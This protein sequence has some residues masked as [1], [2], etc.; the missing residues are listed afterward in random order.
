MERLGDHIEIK[1]GYAFKS[2]HYDN[3]GI[4]IIRIANVQ[5]GFISDADPKFYSLKSKAELS[6]YLISVNDILMSL[7]GNVGRVGLFPEKL[8][9]AYVNQRVC[10][11]KP[12]SESLFN[13]YLFHYL[14]SEKFEFDAINASNGMA[15]LNLST[16]WVESY[17]IPLPPLETQRKIAAILDKADELVQNDKKILEKYDQL[18]Q[19][20]FLEMFGKSNPEFNK[21]KEVAI[22]ELALQEKGSMRTGPFGSDL[23]HSEFV[24]KGIA[25]LGIDNAVENKFSWKG[26]RFITTDKYQKLKRY[27]IKPNDVIITIM[28]TLGRSAVVPEDIDLAIN[29]KHLAAIT[30]NKK[31]CN[32][33][34]LSFALHSDPFL[35][36][37]LKMR[38]RGAIMAGLN[39]TIIKNLKIKYPP[40]ELQNRF[41]EIIKQIEIQKQ[42]A[43][44]SLQKSEEL[45]RGLLQGVFRGKIVKH[46][47]YDLNKKRLS[48]AAEEDVKYLSSRK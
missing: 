32:P 39:L 16:K 44:Q 34:Y 25:V 29:T 28:G 43:R 7:T 23:L 10:I 26:R 33:Y 14:N 21:R 38:E 13:N 30:L 19:S 22:Q 45:F 8:L 40:I 9:P 20:V 18:A 31:K 42:V 1:N 48:E 35:Q 11:I 47:E 27:T 41:A 4:R 17:K 36:F 6:S 46:D 37:Q 15:Q 24:E 5:K 12:N 3:E 2:S